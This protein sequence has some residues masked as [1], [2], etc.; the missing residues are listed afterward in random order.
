[1]KSEVL[2]VNNNP[3]VTLTTYL[4][5]LYLGMA[6]LD[7][8]PAIL[9]LPGGGYRMC[10]DSEAEPIALAYMAEG[11]QAFV[12]RYS[13]GENSKF[14]NPLHDAED[15]LEHIRKN[16]DA[17]HINKDKIAVIGFS[18]GGHLAACLGTM[19][20]IRPAAMVLLYAV[21]KQM[22]QGIV[23]FD[24]PDT[25][26]AVDH[27]TPPAFLAAAT[28][29]PIVPMSN[30]LQFA[31]ALD[32]A[33]VP[34]ELHIFQEGG[35]GFSL[36]KRHVGDGNIA[37]ESR[38]LPLWF[39]LSVDWLYGLLGDFVVPEITFENPIPQKCDQYS[40]DASLI[41]LWE[42]IKCRNILIK[43][44]PQLADEKTKKLAM[45]ISIRTIAQFSPDIFSEGVLEQIDTELKEV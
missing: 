33:G 21:T 6:Y 27:T 39:S 9:V 11:F 19:G 43:Y 26:G 40:I 18:A 32:D 42:N 29:D 22:E 8:R 36:G 20:R 44:V 17:W 7:E 12:L 30:S 2:K 4:H 24:I 28:Q 45:G 3:N 23:P 13:I 31:Q 10:S 1:M 15:A 38:N 34:F 37:H 14:P 5:D 25:V 16:A 35:H 41:T